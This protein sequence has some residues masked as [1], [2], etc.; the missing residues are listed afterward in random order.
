MVKLANTGDLKSPAVKGLGVRSPFLVHSRRGWRN[1]QTH[2]M[3]IP[4]YHPFGMERPKRDVLQAEYESSTDAHLALLY[5]VS[6]TTIR[7]WR[8]ALGVTGKP[9]GNRSHTRTIYSEDDLRGA[10]ST[11]ISIADVM[12]KLGIKPAGGSHSHISRKLRDLQIDT[13]HFLGQKA[14]QLIKRNAQ[15]R[16]A[17]DILALRT[18]GMRTKPKILCR[19]LQEKGRE[20]KCEGCGNH[21]FWLDEPLALQV[22]HKNRDWLDDREDN[23]RILC[24]NCHSQTKG[25]CNRKTPG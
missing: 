6:P 25:W 10:V 2:W 23:L 20:L 21:S 11:S 3:V 5:G 18:S 1:W 16:S 24:P 22:D 4:L 14:N 12:R 15:R 9:R 8:N 7:R 13:S 19:A 17:D